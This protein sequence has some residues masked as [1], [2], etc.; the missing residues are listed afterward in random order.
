MAIK[1]LRFRI[2]SIAD[3]NASLPGMPNPA[4]VVAVRLVPVPVTADSDPDLPGTGA[5][6][7]IEV[8]FQ[9]SATGQ[10]KFNLRHDEEIEVVLRR[11]GQP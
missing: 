11:P 5:S 10:G 8:Y 7:S 3:A 1:T 4:Q 9:P 2:A 6:G